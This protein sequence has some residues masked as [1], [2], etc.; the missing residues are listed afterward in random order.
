MIEVVN[1]HI[2]PSNFTH[3][4]RIL[5]ET[6]SIVD[7]NLVDSLDIVAFWKPGLS[8]YE[9]LDKK[10][11]VWRVP[12]RLG[13][14]PQNNFFKGMKFLEFIVKI[15]V[16]Y[17]NKGVTIVNCHTLSV[18]PLGVVFKFLFG[19]KLIYDAHE[20][21]TETA[22]SHGIRRCLAKFLERVCI[23]YCDAMVV[24]SD[25]IS[26]WYRRKY[27]LDSVH[28]IKN[29][30]Y[31]YENRM[32]NFSFLKKIFGIKLD[33]ILFIYQGVLSEQR[34]VHALLD[35]FSRA[36]SK[37]HIVFMGFGP[38]ED[39]IKKY[40]ELY[41]NIHFQPPVNPSNVLCYSASADVGVHLIANTCLNHYYCMPNK[42]FEYIMSGLP[43]IVS[44]FPEMA[45]IA[46]GA[47]CGWTVSEDKDSI[48]DLIQILTMEE[49]KA[50]KINVQ[51]YREQIGW[52]QEELKLQKL[53]A[54]LLIESKQVNFPENSR[55]LSI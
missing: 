33:E 36:D 28:V 55:S 23:D 50:K 20:L 38:L 4:T 29:V 52:E 41:P 18:L 54:E 40:A 32:D 53:Y 42:V 7:K 2:Y 12:I 9:K 27:D 5:K 26:E 3:E 11:S 43:I 30:P 45:K 19:S 8:E 34:G 25:S 1:L 37:K 31:R 44:D 49:I 17:R 35:A 16:R 21:E 46:K 39:K 13:V 14:L 48:L 47:K 6:K 10:R 15:L 51:K 22:G 24:V